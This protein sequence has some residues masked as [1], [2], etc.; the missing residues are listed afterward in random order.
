[1]VAV[2]PKHLSSI[3]PNFSDPGRPRHVCLVLLDTL[4]QLP[5][6][7]SFKELTAEAAFLFP[8]MNS[9][10]LENHLGLRSLRLDSNLMGFSEHQDGRVHL[11]EY[12]RNVLSLRKR[13]H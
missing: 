4:D 7:F 10:D 5:Q 3:L 13:I 9:D 11:N 1:M 6:G 2:D 8:L 12:Y